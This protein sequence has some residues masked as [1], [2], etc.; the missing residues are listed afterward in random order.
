MSNKNVTKIEAQN[1]FNQF[2]KEHK[3]TEEGIG[4]THYAFGTPYGKFDIPD[5]KMEKFFKVYCDAL[6]KGCDLHMIEKPQKVGPLLIDIDFHL[7]EEN[8]DRMYNINDIKCIITNAT[9]V[10]KEHYKCTSQTTLAFVFEKAKPSKRE[11]KKENT[12]EWKDGFHIV[13][14][15]IA[16]SENMRCYIVDSIKKKVIENESFKHIPYV[17]SIDEVFDTSV[18]KS[19]GWLMYGSRKNEGPLYVLKKIYDSGLKEINTKDYKVRDL[20]KLLSNRKFDESDES[21]LKDSID[22][23]EFDE[24]I[25]KVAID[26][27]IVKVNRK[28]QNIKKKKNDD[29]DDDDDPDTIEN[30]K[31]DVLSNRKERSQEKAKTN[32]AKE[33]K[34]AKGLIQ[35]MSK[36]RS[37]KYELWIKVGWALYNISATLLDAFKEFSKKAG[38]KYNEESCEKIWSSARNDGLGIASIRHWARLDDPD[39][40]EQVM[41]ENINGLVMEAESGTEFDVA[42]VVYEL[43]KDEYKCVDINR[44]YWFEFQGHRWVSVPAAYTLSTRIS[45]EV[46]REFGLLYSNCMKRT[47][48]KMGQGKD[49]TVAK[50]NKITKI[51]NNLKSTGFKKR[52]IEECRNKFYD[53]EFEEKLDSNRN[54]IGYN[55]GVYDLEL[56]CFREGCPDDLISMSVGYDYEEYSEDHPYIKDIIDFFQKTHRDKDM[57]EYIL[58]LMASYL[59]GH[60]KNENFVLWTG[61]GANGKSKTVELFQLGFGDYCGVLPITVLTRKRGGMGQATPEL[62]EMKGKRFVV[63]QEPEAN[64]E[65]QVGLMK[66]LTGGDWIY[67]RRLF[68]DPFRYKPQFKLLLTCNRLPHIPS[69]DNG[70]WRRLRVSKWESEFVDN[71]TLPH[72]FQK[73]YELLEKLEL[74]KKAFIWYLLKVWYP[75]FKK[76]GLKEPAKVTQFTNNYKK[77]SDIYLEFI[78]STLELTKQGKD[79][80]TYDVLY[81]SFKYWYG[82]SYSGKPPPKKELVEY[83]VNNNYKTDKRYMYGVTFKV[84]EDKPKKLDD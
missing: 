28:K 80:E 12:V 46:T 2:L 3:V 50:L 33:I 43:F 49:D 38:K 22:K 24:K 4:S 69:T 41:T 48:G 57:R 26:Y 29:D 58:T 65:I 62:A 70:T 53:A 76:N 16:L 63:F 74:W 10:I 11:N 13:Y 34:L 9:S 45:E 23:D 17:N 67:A 52:V 19:N 83:L 79:F 51:V 59:D 47:T 37:T 25:L 66:E 20:V 15:H 21:E 40:Y 14:P 64:D 42:N 7:D 71:P 30:I 81:A 54:L 32:K 75:I 82:E 44:N 72:Q 73:D 61:S 5:D 84:D 27:G 6:E 8:N 31:V 68:G 60:T 18:I 78:D 55:N 77:A 1:L 35:I 56:S 39:G 36:E